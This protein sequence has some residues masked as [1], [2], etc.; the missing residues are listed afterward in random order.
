MISSIITSTDKFL[1]KGVS[2]LHVAMAGF[3]SLSWEAWCFSQLSWRQIGK[4]VGCLWLVASR[5]TASKVV[6]WTPDV[7]L[8]FQNQEWNLWHG[9]V[10]SILPVK[11][12]CNAKYKNGYIL[13][14]P[15]Y[16]LRKASGAP[17]NKWIIS[18]QG[19]ISEFWQ[20]QKTIKTGAKHVS[21]TS[22]Q[23]VFWANSF[24]REPQ[25]RTLLFHPRIP[26]CYR[27]FATG[28]L[29]QLGISKI[30]TDTC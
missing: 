7:F 11:H 3:A 15:T 8:T 13:Q 17:L 16:L 9:T 21:D 10:R 12:R 5:E 14:M 6:S 23:L 29:A 24:L 27:R 2:L 30:S 18:K 25:L 20:V 28:H 4:W 26:I 1:Q 19:N 22:K